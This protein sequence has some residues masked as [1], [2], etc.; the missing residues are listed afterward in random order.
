[1]LSNPN[2]KPPLLAQEAAKV[3]ISTSYFTTEDR[4]TTIILLYA[5]VKDDPQA[6][7]FL[8]ALLEELDQKEAASA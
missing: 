2:E 7:R 3:Q 4:N 6:R 8:A 5:L 1:M